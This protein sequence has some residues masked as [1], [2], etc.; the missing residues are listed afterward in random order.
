MLAVLRTTANFLNFT[1]A[2]CIVSFVI[3]TAMVTAGLYG[4]VG[5][6]DE[7]QAEEAFRHRHP[8]AATSSGP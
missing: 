8:T 5:Q 4:R 7:A 6:A 1:V 2:T 3:G